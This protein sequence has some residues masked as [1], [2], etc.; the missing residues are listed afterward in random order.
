MSKLIIS[1]CML[2]A[3]T[4]RSA[5]PYVPITPD[6]IAE[7]VVRCAKAGAAIVHL[8]ARDDEGKNTMETARFVEIF[9][10]STTACKKAGVDVVF[11]LTS[12]GSK[13]PIEMRLAHLKLLRPEMCSY[14][15]GSINWANSYVF[16]NEPKFLEELGKTC[17]EEDIKPEMEIFDGGMMGNVQYYVKKG[18]LK[19]PTHYQFMLGVSGGM[20]GNIDSLAY[21]L[22]KLPADATWSISGIGHSHMSCMLAGLSA[23][24]NGLRV[25]LEDN[26]YLSKGVLATNEQLV[27]RAAELS[28]LAGR[29]I[30]NAEEAREILGITRSWH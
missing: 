13:F 11:N 5:T 8:H 10:K 21:F 4:M 1:A 12:S 30:A 25:G 22:P 16:L 27:A 28:K 20:P 7:D 3:G 29:E 19:T 2:G 26:I 15:P 23:G 24:C 18:F 9:E 17:I 14:D 6:E